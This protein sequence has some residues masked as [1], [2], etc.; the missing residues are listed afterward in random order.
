MTPR[1]LASPEAL[2]ETADEVLA[3]F[4]DLFGTSRD[5]AVHEIEDRATAQLTRTE[6]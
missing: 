4:G 2:P 5:L 1:G 3:E 6:R